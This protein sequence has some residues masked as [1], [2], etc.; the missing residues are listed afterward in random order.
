ME[1]Q[2]GSSQSP[3]RLEVVGNF[4][5]LKWRDGSESFIE[6]E[7][8]RR[9]CQCARCA[10]EPDVTGAVRRPAQTAPYTA[11]SFEIRGLERVGQYAVSVEWA[12][13]HNTGIFAWPLLRA[14]GDSAES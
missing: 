11:R 9:A 5:A 4:L 6:L 1:E 3:E 8:L 7:R 12:D 10:G 14:L 2:S 13:G